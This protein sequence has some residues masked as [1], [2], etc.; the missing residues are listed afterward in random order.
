MARP[1]LYH[2][3][4]NANSGKPIIA[5]IEKGVDFESRYTDLLGFDQHKPEYLAV[6][7]AGTIPVLVHGDAVLAESTEMGEYIDAAFDGPPLRPDSPEERWRMRWWG[8]FLDGYFGP[9]LSMIG[10]SVFV[11]P[12][13]RNR[14]PEELR[15]NIERIPLKE[16]RDAW[17][18]AIYNTFSK[19]ELAESLRRVLHGVRVFEEELGKRPYFAGTTY[20]L[21]DINAF[22][23]AYALPLMQAEH[24]N[25]EKTPNLVDWLRRVY[26][27]PAIARSFELGR[28]PMAARTIE[29]RKLIAEDGSDD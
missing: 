4:P 9:S 12:S 8:K 29:V 20:S 16:R 5:L 19:E 3:E 15:R 27:R 25:K 6:N 10:W 24:V 21:A 13:V 28:T 26:A 2:W 1:I 22:C 23:M 17:T 14:D 11:G 7:P 18:K